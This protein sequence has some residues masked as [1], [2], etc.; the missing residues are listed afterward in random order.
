[1]SDDYSLPPLKPDLSLVPVSDDG[2]RGRRIMELNRFRK[3]TVKGQDIYFADEETYLDFLEEQGEE[4]VYH[5]LIYSDCPD[6]L[7][8][9]RGVNLPGID[10]PLFAFGD[11]AYVDRCLETLQSVQCAFRSEFWTPKNPTGKR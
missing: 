3:E 10:A 11:D 8:R 2:G 4:L 6:S 9:I 1:M 5:D 7:D